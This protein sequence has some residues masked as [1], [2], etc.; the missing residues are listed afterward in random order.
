[1]VIRKGQLLRS[2]QAREF[3]VQHKAPCSDCPWARKSLKGWTG[4]NATWR[5]LK[6]ASD[7][8]HPIACHT[9]QI[10][11]GIRNVLRRTTNGHWECA[12]AAI[13]R[14]NTK[15]YFFPER[16]L[17]RLPENKV[18]VFSSPEEFRAHHGEGTGD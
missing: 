6:V 16:G 1:M 17:L 11:R 7:Y 13:Y 2:D 4:P 14:A 5:W 10:A 12:G 18:T 3:R 15:V 8:W 9:R